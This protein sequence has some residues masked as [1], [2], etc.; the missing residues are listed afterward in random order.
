MHE[1]AEKGISCRSVGRH[2]IRLHVQMYNMKIALPCVCVG[3]A[4]AVVHIATSFFLCLL[5]RGSK[6]AR[7]PS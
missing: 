7:G 5:F 4:F 3:Q 6:D 1:C 2:D